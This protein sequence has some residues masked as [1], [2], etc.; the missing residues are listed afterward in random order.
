[1]QENAQQIRQVRLILGDQLNA[2]HSWF[3]GGP[4]P[5]H[6]YLMMEVRS[7]TDYARHHVQKV[8]AFFAA[9]RH[10]AD[11]L[12][13]AGHR[14]HYVVLDD[15]ANAQSIA[16]NI[17][18]I[19]AATGARSVGWMLPDEWRVDEHL[20]E[21]TEV[22]RS[23]GFAVEI[24]DTEHF[25]THRDELATQFKGKKTYLMESF[26][27][28][29]RRKHGV[30]LE[31]DGE[32]T[33]G[34]WNFDATNRKKL[35]KQIQLPANPLHPLD[36]DPQAETDPC[37]VPTDHSGAERWLEAFLAQRLQQFGAYEDAIS[38][39][40]HVLWHSVLTPMLNIGLLTPQQVLD[41]TLARAEAGDVPLNSLEGFVRQIIGWREF[42]ALMYRHHGV[43]LRNGN[44]W[45]LEDRPIP[46]AFYTGE[47]GLPPIDAVIQRVRRSGYCHHIERLMLLGNVNDQI[48][49]LMDLPSS[50]ASIPPASAIGSWSCSSMPTTG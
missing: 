11:E 2:R 38:R 42:M 9:M 20:R 18:K 44:F 23:R 50:A 43:T 46:E 1:M 21:A 29:M 15:P 16:G 12:R 30:L 6:L 35:P 17:D 24:A 31:P 22:W 28:M 36:A 32:P 37:L 47:T 26:Y 27:R 5:E 25:L 14:V 41:R 40:H 7:E 13:A 48:G 45:G 34:A 33:G 10:F 8:L 19:L 4:N 39:E 49:R 3:E